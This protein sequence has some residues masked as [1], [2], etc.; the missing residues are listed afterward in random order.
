MTD[1][2]TY[3]T[4]GT[5][6]TIEN[7]ETL[8]D[9][10]SIASFNI[11]ALEISTKYYQRIIRNNV[12]L[13]LVLSTASGTISATRLNSS[14]SK[15][16]AF[17]LNA[18]FTVM[19]FTISLFTG[20]IKIYQVQERLEMFIKVKQ[21]WIVFST[22]LVS[23]L[24]LPIKL[25]RDAL[26]LILK[27]KTQYL[28]LL[29]IDLEIPDFIK[30]TVHDNLS[31]NKDP[32]LIHCTTTNLSEII[33]LISTTAMNDVRK[34]SDIENNIDSKDASL[35]DTLEKDT[36][37]KDTLEKDTLEKNTL[38]KDTLEKNTL[39]K[40]T[41]TRDNLVKVDPVNEDNLN[42]DYVNVDPVNINPVKL[43]I[44]KQKIFKK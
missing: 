44:I 23:E 41:S 13:G 7:V 43:N 40:N 4:Y 9:W 22:S 21:D 19:S 3:D 2:N 8:V 37:E 20:Y 14:G 12:I 16:S 33:I 24:Q 42:E 17:M 15:D 34:N 25:R 26:F 5:N 35:K 6:W 28:D 38:E 32:S 11:E 10:L 39:E 36:L 1:L 30:K 27:N 29:K 18:L 31:K